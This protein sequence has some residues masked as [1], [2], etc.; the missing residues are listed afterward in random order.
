MR[1][2]WL[3]R[4]RVEVSHARQYIEQRNSGGAQRVVRAIY[5]TVE[6]IAGEPHLGRPGRVVRT[7]ELVVARTPY[8]VAYSVVGNQVVILSVIHGAQEWPDA[9]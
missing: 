3:P 1:I 6:R 7:R 5:A 4:A 2:T 9:F 8:V